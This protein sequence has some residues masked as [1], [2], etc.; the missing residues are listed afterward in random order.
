MPSPVAGELVEDVEGDFEPPP[1]HP[2]ASSTNALNTT[3]A[4]R[5]FFTSSW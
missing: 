4:E 5:H 2:T 3:D 1:L